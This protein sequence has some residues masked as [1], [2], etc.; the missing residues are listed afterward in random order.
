MKAWIPTPGAQS[1][2][3]IA[4]K[5]PRNDQH[6]FSLMNAAAVNNLLRLHRF[7]SQD[8]I[9]CC[10][11]AGGGFISLQKAHDNA[12]YRSVRRVA[13]SGLS[14]DSLLLLRFSWPSLID[15]LSGESK[16]QVGSFLVLPFLSISLSS[17]RRLRGWTRP[18]G[19]NFNMI[20]MSQKM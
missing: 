4:S 14:E 16:L 7:G 8:S 17:C 1:D 2:W 10:E 18:S 12:R 20:Q 6:C 9:P 19:H 15:I 11:A 13:L 5:Q 3:M